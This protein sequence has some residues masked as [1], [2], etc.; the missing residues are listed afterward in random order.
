MVETLHN[1]VTEYVDAVRAECSD[2]FGNE[3]REVTLRDLPQIS[4]RFPGL[5]EKEKKL[6]PLSRPVPLKKSRVSDIKKNIASARASRELS[7]AV[8]SFAQGRSVKYNDPEVQ[9]REAEARG[10]DSNFVLEGNVF[11]RSTWLKFTLSALD[12]RGMLTPAEARRVNDQGLNLRLRVRNARANAAHEKANKHL[13]GQSLAK[14]RSFAAQARG[15]RARA[16]AGTNKDEEDATELSEGSKRLATERKV[17]SA[18]IKDMIDNTA[19]F[20]E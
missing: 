11:A 19:L 16:A 12:A 14:C 15:K 8:H 2:V 20:E 13:D 10:I 9:E 3:D 17:Q 1:D 18:I 4:L 5:E 7:E 6:Q